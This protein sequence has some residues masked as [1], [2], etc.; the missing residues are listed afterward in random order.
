MSMGYGANHAEVIE[1][2]DIR[3]LCPKESRQFAKVLR[4]LGLDMD[5]GL[6]SLD[7]GEFVGEWS[8]LPD[9]MTEAQAQECVQSA[10]DQLATAF[11]KQTR[12]RGSSLTLLAGY[13]DQANHGDRYDELDGG[14]FHVEGNWQLSPSGK[15]LEKIIRRRFFVTFG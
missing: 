7:I 11:Q 12:V 14:Y 2:E 6:Q 1:W 8:N 5:A 10:F 9:D 3:K 13:H 4:K 15:K